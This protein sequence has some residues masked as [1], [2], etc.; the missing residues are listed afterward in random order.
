MDAY[1]EG[2]NKKAKTLKL[3]SSTGQADQ[4][5]SCAGDTSF[6]GLLRRFY[7]AQLYN[8]NK[9]LG[10]WADTLTLFDE[11]LV[12]GRQLS[13]ILLGAKIS[14]FLNLSLQ[15]SFRSG[16]SIEALMTQLENIGHEAH[17]FVDG[18]NVELLDFQRQ[19]LQWTLERE[20][21]EGGIQTLLWGK[22]PVGQGRDI[23]FNP[24][25]NRF[26]RDVPALVRGGFIAEEM[27]LGKTVIS[28][29]LILRNPAPVLP[30]SGSSISD[31]E[32]ITSPT[33]WD[34]SLYKKNSTTNKKR[35]SILCRGTLVIVSVQ[36]QSESV[37]VAW[38]LS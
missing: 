9:H 16:T 36:L 6:N 3:L 22:V 26:R 12:F 34:K 13:E 28:L 11:G 33:Q 29:A 35:G 32:W 20:T 31:L 14:A 10:Q 30:E 18:L 38:I 15:P 27:G 7:S 5:F 8:E 1:I 37:S 19:T 24:I 21:M 25:L 4:G 17:G 2:R 23:Y